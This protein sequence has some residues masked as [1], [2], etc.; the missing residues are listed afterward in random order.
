MTV[1][2]LFKSNY[3]PSRTST[4]LSQYDLH[5]V[6]VP[7]QPMA[8]QVYYSSSMVPSVFLLSRQLCVQLTAL[9]VL[10]IFRQLFVCPAFQK[11]FLFAIDSVQ[12]IQSI[13]ICNTVHQTLRVFYFVLPTIRIS[14]SFSPMLQT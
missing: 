10:Q 3:P 5:S 12:L 6:S 4:F 7:V 13:R 8:I 9:L 11:T 14:L 1:Q 2:K